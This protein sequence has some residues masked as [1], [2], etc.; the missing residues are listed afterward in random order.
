MICCGRRRISD[1]RC[2]HAPR[3]LAM[4]PG[5]V[6]ALTGQLSAQQAPQLGLYGQRIDHTFSHCGQYIDEMKSAFGLPELPSQCG[7]CQGWGWSRMCNRCVVRFASPRPRCRRCALPVR[8][9]GRGLRPLP[10]R[11][12][13][14][15][16][17]AGRAR[18]CGAVGRRDHTLQVSLRAR[19]RCR[20]R[21]P[22]ARRQSGGAAGDAGPDRCRRRSARA[23]C[24][25][26]ATTRPGSWRAGWR[27]GSAHRPARICCC[28]CATR[29]R[30]CRCRA[31]N[32]WPTSAMPLRSSRCAATNW[33]GRDVTVVDD[34]MTTGATAEEISFAYCAKPAPLECRSGR[35]PGRRR[36]ANE[37]A[38]VPPRPTTGAAQPTIEPCST[39]F[40]S[41]PK[42]RPI[43]AT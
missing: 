16:P 5:A 29:R 39:S 21:R 8:R 27:G 34:V 37:S 2:A 24:A 10:D 32:A 22:P 6:A 31:R 36:L 11:A 15:R 25:N 35:W 17:G 14:P 4:Q 30:S 7:I 38:I 23:A 43:P 28:A 18:L 19:L 40:W 13:R 26:A 1:R 12:T 9:S 41:I 3:H 20:A 33:H 42:F